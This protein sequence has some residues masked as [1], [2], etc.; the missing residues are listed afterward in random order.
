[1]IN[2][3][4]EKHM[5]Q[6]LPCQR[7]DTLHATCHFFS[8]SVLITYASICRIYNFALRVQLLKFAGTFIDL[9]S[10]TA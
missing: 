4:M 9:S 7:L 3:L 1:M 5:L 6:A 2:L 10:F 8:S